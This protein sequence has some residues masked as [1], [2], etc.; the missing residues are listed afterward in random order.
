MALLVS[1]HAALVWRLLADSIVFCA[2]SA[3]V[4][5]YLA[6]NS[7]VQLPSVVRIV[8]HEFGGLTVPDFLAVVTCLS[9]NSSYG[10]HDRI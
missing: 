8:C 10:S 2:N 1:K 9:W 5:L 3:V 4:V 7:E 6:R